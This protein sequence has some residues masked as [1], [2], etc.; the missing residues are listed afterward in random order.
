MRRTTIAGCV[1]TF[2]LVLA[3]C[4]GST[5]TTSS[6]S[7]TGTAKA[8]TSGTSE[9]GNEAT[10]V[11]TEYK[12]QA[13]TNPLKAGEVTIVADNQGGSTHEIVIVAETDAAKLPTKDDGSVDEDQ[14]PDAVKRGEIDD[15]AGRTKKSGSFDLK[16]GTYLA[17]CNVVDETPMP[18]NSPSH[19]K[20]GM[21]TTFTVA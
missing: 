19:F 2:G 18:P 9:S 15:V 3:G 5:S 21:Y 8:A 20:D 11:L 17:F 4:G 7:T 16:P 6:S 1:M 10:F 12:I 13:P 14:I